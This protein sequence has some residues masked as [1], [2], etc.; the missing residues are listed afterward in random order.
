MSAKVLNMLN[1]LQQLSRGQNIW[2]NLEGKIN[3]SICSYQFNNLSSIPFL[4]DI[5][6]DIMVFYQNYLTNLAQT[7]SGILS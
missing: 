2:I 3:N 5:G 6:V 1:F 4:K 7:P